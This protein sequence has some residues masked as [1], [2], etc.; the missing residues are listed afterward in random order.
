MRDLQPAM[1]GAQL[2]SGGPRDIYTAEGTDKQR[3]YLIPSRRLIIVRFADGGS[4][5]DQDFLSRLL[6]GKA[7]PDAHTHRL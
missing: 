4:F 1:D 5:S 6:T 7:K 3:L 2:F